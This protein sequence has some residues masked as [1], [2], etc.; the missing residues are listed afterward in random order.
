MDEYDEEK[1]NRKKYYRFRERIDAED[2]LFFSRIGSILAVQSILMMVVVTINPETFGFRFIFALLGLILSW[3]TYKSAR[4]NL[5]M[6]DALHKQLKELGIS[7]EDDIT[8]NDKFKVVH[9]WKWIV[10]WIFGVK[11]T[12]D[13]DKVTQSDLFVSFCYWSIGIWLFIIAWLAW[14]QGFEKL[15]FIRDFFK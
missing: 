10:R 13:K 15:T 12:V 7:E 4:K 5:N 11:K 6:I 3:V 1:E 14:P 9:G 8:K 2:S